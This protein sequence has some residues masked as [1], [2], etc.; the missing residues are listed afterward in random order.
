MI[1]VSYTKTDTYYEF[2]GENGDKL[3]MPATDVILVDDETGMLAIKSTASRQTL[4][5]YRK[6]YVP[7][8]KYICSGDPATVLTS[9]D[10]SSGRFKTTPGGEGRLPIIPCEVWCNK[11]KLYVE[12]GDVDEGTTMR[13]MSGWWDGPYETISV[14][15]NQTVEIEIT[16]TIINDCAQGDCDCTS[17]SNWHGL[18]LMAMD[19]NIKL[20]SVYY[21]A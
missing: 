8:K 19:G 3:I 4:G 14:S 20:N 17:D 2:V 11:Y 12:L 21:Y 13:V 6:P 1:F 15:S 7:T 5:L 18:C 16:D 10:A 9:W